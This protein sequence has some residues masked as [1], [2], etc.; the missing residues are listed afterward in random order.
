MRIVLL[1]DTHERHRELDV[2]DADLLIHAGDATNNGELDAIRDF[3]DWLGEL[4]H[5]HK[6][7]V[8][9]NHDRTFETAPDKARPL[10]RNATYLV[11]ATEVVEGI[12][13][14][15]SPWQPEFMSWAFNV[16][17]GKAIRE[18][19]ALIPPDTDVLI[20]HGPPIGHGDRLIHGE[21]VGCEELALRIVALD[22]RLHVF[23]HIHEGYGTTQNALTLHANASTCDHH[24]EP[25]HPPILLE[26]KGRGA[27]PVVLEGAGLAAASGRR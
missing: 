27:V 12:R 11:D 3:D 7:F 17:R 20:T 5:R 15:G 22:V 21:A 8:P 2:P 16:P 10:I 6:I 4:P 13:I 19:W 23:G 14:W 1:S 25:T 9:G 18:K 26:W 24:Y